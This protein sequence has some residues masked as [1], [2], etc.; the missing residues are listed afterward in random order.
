VGLAFLI[1]SEN[2]QLLSERKVLKES[3]Y[4][5]LLDAS[6][7]LDT[8]RKEARRLVQQAEHDAHEARRQGFEAGVEE[9]RAEYAERLIA[10]AADSEAHLHGMREAMARLVAKA[11]TQ[12]IADADPALL[13]EAAL[14]RVDALIRT[15]P[16]VS[17][18]VAPEQ[19]ATLRLVLAKLRGEA[20]WTMNVNVQADPTLPEGGC[21]LQTPSGTME[22][23]VEAQIEAFRRAI[24]R[25]GG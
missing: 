25:G 18:R 11:V 5:A 15:E 2:L 14:T 19:E 21:V 16:Y 3:E 23:G 1:T 20:Q 4:A 9:A 10:V 24:E 8:A 13:F 12:F 17:V 6:A 22:I 7:V